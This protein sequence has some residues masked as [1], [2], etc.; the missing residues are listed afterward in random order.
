MVLDRLFLLRICGIQSLQSHYSNL[1]YTEE[2]GPQL[3]GN[4][5]LLDNL[6]MYRSLARHICQLRSQSL[7]DHLLSQP[8]HSLFHH[9]SIY[10]LL[11]NHIYQSLD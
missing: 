11:G 4:K 2:V 3:L 8:L 10:S 5:S 9:H 7:L 6:S 1:E